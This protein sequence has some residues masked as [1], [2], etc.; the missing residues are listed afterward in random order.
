MQ[1]SVCGGLG[2]RLFPYL[3]MHLQSTRAL[4]DKHSRKHTHAH[5]QPLGTFLMTVSAPKRSN[6]N[7]DDDDDEYE[8]DD[9]DDDVDEDVCGGER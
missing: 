3:S 6:N 8:Y 4:K 5:T 2:L 9:D 7:N 1:S